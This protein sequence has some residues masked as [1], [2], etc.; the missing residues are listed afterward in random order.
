MYALPDENWIATE[1]AVALQ[2]EQRR[3]GLDRYVEGK[4]DCTKFSWHAVDF[5][6]Q[7]HLHTQDDAEE[8]TAIAFGVFDYIKPSGEGHSI[9]IAICR[10][11]DM[12]LK[13]V[14]FEPQ[15]CSLVIPSRQQGSLCNIFF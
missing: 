2:A 8:S 3:L 14:Y 4:N 9:N 7:C 13:V 1:F 5:A 10:N 15:L 12:T 6:A 11:E